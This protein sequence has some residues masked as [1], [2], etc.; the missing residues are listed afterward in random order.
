[1]FVNKKAKNYVN[2]IFANSKNPNLKEKNKKRMFCLQT[3]EDDFSF[4]IGVEKCL[5][6]QK[7]GFHFS[8][9]R[10]FACHSHDW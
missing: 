4:Q 2:S 1:M 5:I 3:S 6:N 10:F 9:G 7:S 8:R